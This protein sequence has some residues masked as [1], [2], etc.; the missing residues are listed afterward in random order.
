[1]VVCVVVG[2]VCRCWW[3]ASLLVTW[4]PGGGPT[5]CRGDQ[6]SGGGERVVA[7]FRFCGARG[8]VGV[9][10]ALKWLP[11]PTPAFRSSRDEQGRAKQ[12]PW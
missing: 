4:K 3:R 7:G 5:Q 10:V 8:R 11:A 2:G 12:L 1:L 6:R 9:G